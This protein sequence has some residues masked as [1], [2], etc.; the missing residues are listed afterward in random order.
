M[1]CASNQWLLV[2]A[3]VIIALVSQRVQEDFKQIEYRKKSMDERDVFGFVIPLHIWLDELGWHDC[4]ASKGRLFV[5][6]NFQF[7]TN[8]N[9]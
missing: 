7:M 4:I 1:D 5:G 9:R 8:S 3:K 6:N 2:K